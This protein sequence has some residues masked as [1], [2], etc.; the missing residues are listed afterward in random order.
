[1]SLGN[2]V[3]NRK[4]FG[5]IDTKYNGKNVRL[6]GKVIG[7]NESDCTASMI[8][9]DGKSPVVRSG[10]PLEAIELDEGLL[11]DLGKSAKRAAAWVKTKYK[12]VAGLARS[13]Y[14]GTIMPVVNSLMIGQYAAKGRL[15]QFVG[16]HPSEDVISQAKA[17]G[18][19]VG[20]QEAV[21][22]TGR[23]E[24]INAFWR[25][26]VDKLAKVNESIADTT[27]EDVKN[28]YIEVA[29][30]TNSL[31]ESA[32]E[33][34]EENPMFNEFFSQSFSFKNLC[35]ACAGSEYTREILEDASFKSEINRLFEYAADDNENPGTQSYKSENIPEMSVG[36]IVN[37][38]MMQLK[39]VFGEGEFDW[40]S[41]AG[42]K[43][44][45]NLWDGY[46][47][48][49]KEG[50]KAKNPNLSEDEI[51][52]QAEDLADD[53]IEAIQKRGG[54]KG[55]KPIMIWGAPG[56]GKTQTVQ[57]T[58]AMFSKMTGGRRNISMLEVVLSKME[59]DDFS[60]PS[61]GDDNRAHN[62]P[63]SWLPIWKV[64]G[65]KEE[66][67][68]RD[69]A[70][71]A[72][73]NFDKDS[74]KSKGVS[75]ENDKFG[76]VSASNE[77]FIP[78]INNMDY[79]TESRRTE[80]AQR[81]EDMK[82]NMVLDGGI[83]FFDEFTRAKH[84]VMNVCMNL[85]NDR[86]F[87]EGWH[88]G[89]HW[90]IVCAGNRFYEMAGQEVTWESAF[91]TRFLQ[92]TFV[93]KFEDWL[94][95]A[96]G[97]SIDPNTGNYDTS[98]KGPNKIDQDIIDFLR[99]KKEAAWYENVDD[100][101]VD[102]KKAAR[103]SANPRSW[104]TAS[105]LIWDKAVEYAKR[106]GQNPSTIIGDREYYNL[107]IEDKL[108]A[109]STAIGMGTA[110]YK[111]FHSFHTGL[112]YMTPE[113]YKNVWRTGTLDGKPVKDYKNPGSALR[114]LLPRGMQPEDSTLM[115]LT[116]QIMKM[117]PKSWK[118]T[119]SQ[120]LVNV[121]SYI[122]NIAKYRGGGNAIVSYVVDK[123]SDYMAPVAAEKGMKWGVVKD[124]AFYKFIE[125]IASV[126]LSFKS[127]INYDPS[128]S[129]QDKAEE[130]MQ[131]CEEDRKTL[132]DLA[133]ANGVDA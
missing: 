132:K 37:L 126:Y 33:H 77:T 94:M 64:S 52:E 106:N 3:R 43:F 45:D 35:E 11:D 109:L 86:Q 49:F 99:A 98:R 44:L 5:Y 121:L 107:P 60:L 55:I 73:M 29:R 83:I 117:N 102:K 120:D 67:Q 66:D 42:Q 63:Q 25:K 79:V 68:R 89:S 10:I 88:L 81:K 27:M 47:E 13:L 50:V 108:Q 21:Y 105:N 71:N 101:N 70:A 51:Q 78:K 9:A 76:R 48:E 1:M 65:D 56:I 20:S 26:I 23:D 19:Q 114:S 58:R 40:N 115:K 38:I 127:P 112:K 87:G 118:D 72:M 74:I 24:E 62:A 2:D 16:F 104:E 95:W 31:T 103:T 8:F 122:V 124:P 84:D 75:L 91:G 92:M 113:M 100:E 90:I 111:S 93:P 34:L 119:T 130:L 85:I 53:Q 97:Y 41:D 32:L 96:Q 14:N 54:I 12:V 131:N 110:S 4:F 6:Y 46:V 57:Q 15:P 129:S 17:I 22:D 61:L 123:I 36:E 7:I 39:I 18:V 69:A 59:H 128:Q 30:E 133:A 82:K 125:P 116:E 28:A 80:R